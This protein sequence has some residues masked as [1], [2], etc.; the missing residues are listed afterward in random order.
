MYNI[1]SLKRRMRRIYLNYNWKTTSN[2][3]PNTI[4][5]GHSKGNTRFISLTISNWISFRPDNNGKSNSLC[6]FRRD[7]N[8]VSTATQ[9][10]SNFKLITLNKG[11]YRRNW[12]LLLADDFLFIFYRHERKRLL[13]K[14]LFTVHYALQ[15][16]TAAVYYSGGN[17]CL[18]GPRHKWRQ[19][20]KHLGI[21]KE[22]SFFVLQ[23]AYSHSLGRFVG[24]I[25]FSRARVMKKSN[26]Q[27]ERKARAFTLTKWKSPENKREKRF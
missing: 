18:R 11:A 24:N 27:T 15:D 25:P 21:I 23:A 26:R 19:F 20:R 2:N 22:R 10:V 13:H 16:I 6:Y 5:N 12:N 3:L 9:P 7:Y 1:R 4:T 17:I 8:F 14:F